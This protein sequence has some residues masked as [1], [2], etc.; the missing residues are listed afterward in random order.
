MW[1]FLEDLMESKK[2]QETGIRDSEKQKEM[3]K[4]QRR[5][6]E[7]E[8]DTENVQEGSYIKVGK[9]HV[10]SWK[11]YHFPYI[12]N[13]DGLDEPLRTS[14]LVESEVNGSKLNKVAGDGVVETNLAAYKGFAI[15]F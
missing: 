12:H 10:S 5:D 15:N 2:D 3:G 14:A 1:I 7:N 9:W 6:V 4:E 13:D 11:F 8:R